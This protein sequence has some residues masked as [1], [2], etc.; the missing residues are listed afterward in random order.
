MQTNL[1]HRAQFLSLILELLQP[2][3]I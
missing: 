2:H 1:T 3:C